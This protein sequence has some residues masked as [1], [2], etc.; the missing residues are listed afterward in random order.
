MRAYGSIAVVFG[1]S[2]VS[3][4][5]EREAWDVYLNMGQPSDAAP[6]LGRS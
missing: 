5:A 2:R 4:V 6:Q 3:I 1:G